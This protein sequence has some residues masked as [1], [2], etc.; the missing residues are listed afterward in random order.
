[1]SKRIIAMDIETDGLNATKI[2]VM[3]LCELNPDTMIPVRSWSLTD[4]TKMAELVADKDVTFIT[5]NGHSFDKPVLT[6]LA[7][8][9]NATM[10]CSLG[11]SWYLEPKRNLHGLGAYGEDFGVPKPEVEDWSEQPL[12]VYVHRCEE[13]VKIQTKLWRQQFKH[14][15]LLYDDLEG[16]WH[17]VETVQ[18]KMRALAVQEQ[19]K[20]QIDTEEAESLAQDFLERSEEAKT[21]LGNAMPKVPVTVWKTR[22]KKPF[23]KDGS[24]S[25]TGLKWKDITEEHGF[26]FDH[27]ERIKHQTGWAEPNAGS[28]AQVKA[29][30]Y[31]LGWSPKIH[32]FNRDKETG[33]V[34][35]IPQ[36][37]DA[38]KGTLCPDIIRLIGKHPELKY[39]EELGVLTHRKS[40]VNG[41]LK[42]SDNSGCIVAG[43][44][45]FTNTLRLRHKT[46][47]NIPSTRK[48]YGKEIRGLLIAKKEEN[49]LLGSD[50]CSLEDRI[51]MNLMM[52]FDPEFV[53][54]MRSDD[55]D[56]HL[57]MAVKAGMMSEAESE[58]YK[59]GEA[60]PEEQA[61]L[62]GIRHKGKSTNYASVYGA[63]AATIARA[64][65][66]SE[67]EG[68][69]LHE[70]YWAI[71]W[72]VKAIAD[73][74]IVKESRGMK[75][76]WNPI[77]DMWYHLKVEK[78][79]FSTL[80][81]SS[82]S[83]VFDLWLDKI[84]ARR[85]QVCAQ[86]HDEIILET[87][88][89]D[90]FR[91]RGEAL[92]KRCIAEVNK[93]CKLVVDLDVDVQWGDTYADI[94]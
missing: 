36:L 69:K 55:Y 92:L 31:D 72:S 58:L 37:K 29:W 13:D 54:A 39:L 66:V 70:A 93:E 60:T 14:L 84:L 76:L 62:S 8:E 63:G 2:W 51:K 71:N 33:D 35:R 57:N 43:A 11:L 50:M 65:G 4:T 27:D 48:P 26:T 16:V 90:K 5:H 19:S 89:G 18:R 85:P 56:P 91:K 9:F 81:Q 45:G 46:F 94:H 49:E 86:A 3:S 52:P 24:L 17:A 22:P 25:A 77:A 61:R 67:A 21:N 44:S 59:S 78:D 32:S 34:K 15:N 74:C 83:Y 80:A 41:F 30:L 87:M 47:L 88:R 64:A 68:E 10:V 40:V 75:W 53:E 82:G 6:R 38:D 73:N 7:G 28:H 79:R 1:M 42:G 23:K 12:E 20:F